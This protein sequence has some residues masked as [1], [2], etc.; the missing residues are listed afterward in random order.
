MELL[1]IVHFQGK[2]NFY[3]ALSLFIFVNYSRNYTKTKSASVLVS[4]TTPSSECDEAHA[5]Y[6]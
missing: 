4:A 3:Y 2:E 6:N 1:L 5:I